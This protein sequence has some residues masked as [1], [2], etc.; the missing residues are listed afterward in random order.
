METNERKSL[1]SDMPPKEIKD[2]PDNRGHK[3][4]NG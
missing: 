2:N 1:I 3:K 4:E